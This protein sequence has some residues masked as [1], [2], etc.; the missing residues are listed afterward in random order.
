VIRL[1]FQ[2]KSTKQQ[3]E[4]IA[5]WSTEALQG[6]NKVK[7]QV[8]QP[9]RRHTRKRMSWARKRGLWVVTCAFSRKSDVCGNLVVRQLGG[10]GND[11]ENL[12]FKH[13]YELEIAKIPLSEAATE[14]MY[15]QQGWQTREGWLL[16]LSL[17]E[18]GPS[19]C[20]LSPS[21][22]HLLCLCLVFGMDSGKLEG[23]FSAADLPQVPVGQTME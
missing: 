21:S 7:A 8:S 19:G 22:T 12:K 23:E 13:Q 3:T 6:L 2:V 17:T 9:H 18:T 11:V 16:L 20:L 5:K 14:D 10:L 15:V 4:E 1:E